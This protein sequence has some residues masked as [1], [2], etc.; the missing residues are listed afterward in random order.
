MSNAGANPP[1]WREYLAAMVEHGERVL[2]NTK[3]MNREDF[4]ANHL[5]FDATLRNLQVI[6]QAAQEIPQHIRDAHPEIPWQEIGKVRPHIAHTSIVINYD[7]VWSII[8][9]S[10]PA[11][12]PRL[13]QLVLTY[14]DPPPE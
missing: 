12:I 11:D 9:D 7:A 4:V 13:R 6:G 1:D 3:G 2:A 10:L 5:V 8:R 14:E